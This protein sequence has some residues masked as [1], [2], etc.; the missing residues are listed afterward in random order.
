MH[1]AGLAGCHNKYGWLSQQ[2][3]I[4]PRVQIFIAVY[5]QIVGSA[6]ISRTHININWVS[7]D[8]TYVRSV[9]ATNRR[10]KSQVMYSYHDKQSSC[11][12][13]RVGHMHGHMN[14]EGHR[15]ESPRPTFWS[16]P[17]SHMIATPAFP[18]RGWLRPGRMNNGGAVFV[19]CSRWKG[20]LSPAIVATLVY[21]STRA[22][23]VSE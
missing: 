9:S 12:P 6:I 18:G 5:L 10:K 23:R 2:V 13:V 8:Y 14:I 22:E 7:V 19:T 1:E 3:Y 17:D 21:T 16:P 4:R 15:D 11:E 20:L